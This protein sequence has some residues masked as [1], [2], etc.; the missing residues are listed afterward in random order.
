MRVIVV[1]SNSNT[2]AKSLEYGTGTKR[3][4]TGGPGGGIFV[5]I[6]SPRRCASGVFMALLMTEDGMTVFT[7]GFIGADVSNSAAK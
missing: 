6:S 7:F 3:Y 1:E 4:V 5:S 2:D